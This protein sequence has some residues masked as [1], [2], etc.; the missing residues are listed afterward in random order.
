MP[1]SIILEGTMAEIF[2][3]AEEEL[4]IGFGMI[5]IRGAA[6]F[7]RDDA[8]T[9]FRSVVRDKRYSHEGQTFDLSDCKMLILSEDVSDMIGEELL[10]WQLSGDFPLIVEIPPLAGSSAQHTRLVDAVRK[11]IGI[12]IE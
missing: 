12:K 9:A 2:V 8:I 10:E 4:L 3:L 11:A 5:G 7:N 6:I 1:E